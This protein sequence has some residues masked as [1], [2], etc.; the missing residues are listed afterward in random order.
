[1]KLGCLFCARNIMNLITPY[2]N[3]KWCLFNVDHTQ[4]A[5][6]HKAFVHLIESTHQ[7]DNINRFTTFYSVSLY[8]LSSDL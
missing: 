2:N 1:M 3:Y 5:E 4:H 6:N 7:R 8:P